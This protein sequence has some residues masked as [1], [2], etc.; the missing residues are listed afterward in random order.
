MR[1]GIFVVTMLLSL[2][3]TTRAHAGEKIKL[4]LNWVPEPEFGGIYAAKQ[5]GAFEKHGLDVDIQPGGAGTPTWQLVATGKVDFAVASADE[6]IIARS[7][8]HARKIR[9]LLLE[10]SREQG[11]ARH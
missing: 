3:L 2:T 10:V 5:T 1:L 4:A 8:R 7:Q 11:E 6:V 9:T